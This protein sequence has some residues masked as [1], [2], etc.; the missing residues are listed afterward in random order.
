MFRFKMTKFTLGTVITTYLSN[1]T[2]WNNSFTI[3]YLTGYTAVSNVKKQSNK[4]PDTILKSNTSYVLGE[5][6][7]ISR[8][9][10]N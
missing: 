2:S 3:L 10:D 5:T 4:K 9:T 7:E 6:T 8:S 1:F